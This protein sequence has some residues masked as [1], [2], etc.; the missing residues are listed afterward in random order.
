M[1][2]IILHEIAAIPDLKP[3]QKHN[4]I[5]KAQTRLKDGMH[6]KLW[7]QFLDF[8]INSAQNDRLLR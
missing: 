4:Q 1:G 5:A 8:M 6:S 7:D 3:S 2:K